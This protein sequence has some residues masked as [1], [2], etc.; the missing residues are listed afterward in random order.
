MSYNLQASFASV[1]D[2]GESFVV[3]VRFSQIIRSKATI[4]RQRLPM[5]VYRRQLGHALGIHRPV[6]EG[7]RGCNW[8]AATFHLGKLTAERLIHISD[9]FG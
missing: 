6:D 8:A 1:V 9:V 7:G 4:L 3:R 2:C 5:H